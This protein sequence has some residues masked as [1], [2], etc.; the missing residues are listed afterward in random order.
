MRARAFGGL[1]ALVALGVLVAGGSGAAALGASGQ[2][3]IQGH[4]WRGQPGITE[5][6]AQLEALQ[7][8]RDRRAAERGGGEGV[9]VAPRPGLR[10]APSRGSGASAA[11]APTPSAGVGG[12]SAPFAAGTS[13]LGAQLGVDSPF[14]PPDSGGSVGPSQILVTVN[15][16]FKV[17]DKQGN[18]GALNVDDTTF[19]N[20]VRNGADVSDPNTEYDRL[21]NRWIITAINLEDP[22]NRILIAVSSGP[23][24]TSQSDFTFFTFNQNAPPPAT[25]NGLF[26]DYPTLGVD[27][28][29]LYIGVN[30]FNGNNFAHTSAFVVRKSSVLSGGPMVVTAFRNIGST[31]TAGPFAPQGVQDMDPSVDQGYFVGVDTP[32]FSQIDLRRVN[33]P[34][35]TPTMSANLPVSVPTTRFPINV[36]AQGTAGTLDALDDRLFEAMIARNPN[37]SLSLWTAHNIQVDSSGNASDTGG[38]DGARWYEIG[39]LSGT[40]TLGQSGTEFDPAAVNPRFFWIPSIAA[41]GQGNASL[42]SS[43]AG[44]GRFAAIASMGRLASDPSGQTEPFT[45]TQDS[46]SSYNGVFGEPPDKRWGDFSQTVVDP[47]DN[48]TFWTFQEYAHATNS[49]GVRVIKLMAPPPATPSSASPSVLAAGSPSTKITIAGTSSN[50]SGFFDPGPD[51]GGPGFPN[52]ISATVSGGVGVNSVTVNDPTHVTLDLDTRGASPAPKDVTITN[53]DGQ[54]ATGTDL[55]DFKALR[56]SLSIRYRARRGR[57]KGRLKSTK[58]ACVRRQPVKVFRRKRG[59]DPKIGRDLTNAR[60]KY[61]VRKR[62]AHGRFY[63]KVKKKPIAGVGLCKAARSRTIHLG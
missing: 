44:V 41:N 31:T 2:G 63:A 48:M 14:V 30:E 23:T 32:V 18:P 16:R 22:N 52:H 57:F 54:S 60:G 5:S 58:P 39:N 56:R 6:V 45:I 3:A 62:H 19:W 12:P 51:S 17:F 11:R 46:S 15:G 20:S 49:W 13:F 50:G 25:D 61:A 35:G 28:S 36:P 1:L 29:A 55:L 24:I 4:P 7:H 37:G 26:A 43:T 9:E 38:R 59:P 53:P 10:P 8:R 27:K 42:N 40:P 34:G 33:D 21:S 47:T